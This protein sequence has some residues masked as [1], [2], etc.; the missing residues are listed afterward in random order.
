M[1]P[2]RIDTSEVAAAFN[3]SREEVDDMKELAIKRVALGFQ[4]QWRT[5]ANSELSKVREIYKNAIRISYPSKFTAVV[6]LDA[7]SWISNAIEMGYSS[8]D[9]KVG[10][11]KSDKVRLTKDGNPYLTIPFRF[12][13]PAAIGDN[14]AFSGRLPKEIYG[15]IRAK[16]NNPTPAQRRLGISDIPTQYQIPK[17]QELRQRIQ[18][19]ESIPLSQRTSIYEGLENRG[20]MYMTFRRVSLNSHPDSWIHPGFEERNLA[21]KALDKFKPDIGDIVGNTIDDFLDDL[22]L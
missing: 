22:G 19:I 2:V 15:A 11:L 18:Q 6:Y 20:G 16:K 13:T 21:G 7:V 4:Q 3:L 5:E 10:F 8:F 17:S 14:P 12:S 1:I 9:M